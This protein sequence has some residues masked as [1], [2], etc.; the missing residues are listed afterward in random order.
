MYVST[1][2]TI[3]KVWAAAEVKGA[4]RIAAEAE[5][6]ARI[7]AEA[8]EAAAGGLARVFLGRQGQKL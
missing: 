6:A 2:R 1:K 7:A 4:A 8:E 3:S 5:E